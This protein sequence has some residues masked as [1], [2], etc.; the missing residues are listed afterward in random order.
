MKIKKTTVLDRRS[1][2]QQRIQMEQ[3]KINGE[4]LV[5]PLLRIIY[6]YNSFLS[7]DDMDRYY[8][9]LSVSQ[10]F[11]ESHIITNYI[12]WLL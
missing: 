9:T 12:I 7:K 4:L 8:E 5:V 2:K 3:R 10:L 11:S 6:R 1:G